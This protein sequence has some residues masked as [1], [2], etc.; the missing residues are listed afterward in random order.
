MSPSWPKLLTREPGYILEVGLG[1]VD[2]Y[3]FRDDVATGREYLAKG[4][5]VTASAVLRQALDLWRGPVLADLAEAGI[6]WPDLVAAQNSR[7]DALDD[8]FQAELACGRHHIILGELE[9]LLESHPLREATCAQLMLALYRSGRQ[10]DALNLYEQVRCDLVENLGVD[11]GLKLRELQRAILNHDPSLSEVAVQT[12]PVVIRGPE[13]V[14]SPFPQVPAPFPQVSAPFP[15]VPP[16]FP[17]ASAVPS[18]ESFPPPLPPQPGGAVRSRPVSHLLI[19]AHPVHQ[20]GHAGPGGGLPADPIDAGIREVIDYYGGRHVVLGG[21]CSAVLFGV[22]R[23]TD[24]DATRALLAAL[25]V[26]DRMKKRDDVVVKLAV[27]RGQ[28]YAPPS[29]DSHCSLPNGTGV[30]LDQ[31]HALLA[32]T[33]GQT[34]RVC[35]ETRR[36]VIGLFRF[37]RV[38]GLADVWEVNGTYGDY[39]A[40]CAQLSTDEDP[41]PL[42]DRDHELGMLAQALERTCGRGQSHLVTVVGQHGAGKTRLLAEFEQRAAIRG[43]D[44][45]ARF[46]RVDHG[47]ADGPLWRAGA[48]LP[49]R[50]L[51]AYC[52]I[53]PERGPEHAR[54]RLAAACEAL[55]HAAGRWKELGDRLAPLLVPSAGNGA[56][57]AS[58]QQD[59]LPALRD[60][61]VAASRVRPLV[62]MVDDADDVDETGLRFL[63]SLAE[64]RVEG[65]VPLLV[66]VAARPELLTRFPGRTGDIEHVNWSGVSLAPR[67]SFCEAVR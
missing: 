14:P 34:V 53:E 15:Q 12:R 67:R 51:A 33:D 52:G 36:A 49:K 40:V 62:V 6:A 66:V 25:A 2:L 58:A 18:A 7:L 50:I 26:Q 23:S 57:D 10:V 39:L 31:A 22:Q 42:V 35:D 56:H 13:A 9:K 11:P 32:G 19:C 20:D 21:T 65:P 45:P 48:D 30:L 43:A 59:A 46:V 55:R 8:Y 16:P 60:F 64:D 27:T 61:L 44:T 28:T 5:P 38:D 17:Q 29:A 37:L 41:G 24:R 54:S 4:D 1:R 3:R 47:S 63:E